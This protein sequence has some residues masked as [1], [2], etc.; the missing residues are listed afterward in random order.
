MKAVTAAILLMLP[1]ALPW[2]AWPLP[3]QDGPGHFGQIGVLY[4]QVF[5]PDSYD[6]SLHFQ[7]IFGPNRSFYYLGLAFAAV[8]GPETGA[9]WAL[10]ASLGL[11][12]PAVALGLRWAGLDW[13]G[14]IFATPLALGRLTACGFFP[15][16]AA[17]G[18]AALALGL[19][20]RLGRVDARRARWGLGAALLCLAALTYFTHAFV[21]LAV[22]AYLAVAML[23]A[24]GRR[25][26]GAVA[27]HGAAVLGVIALHAA[28]RVDTGA[29]GSALGAVLAALHAPDAGQLLRA[30]DWVAAWRRDGGVDDG[31]QALWLGSGLVVVWV[32]RGAAGAARWA[33]RLW[34]LASLAVIWVLGE[35]FGPPIR[36]WGGFLRVPSL[37]LL[38]G[39]LAFWPTAASHRGR[40]APAR[41]ASFAAMG[42]AALLVAFHL[43]SVRRDS[44]AEYAGLS[45]VLD[46]APP[47]RR[48]CA[49]W[50]DAGPLAA[51]PG[52]PHWYAGNYYVLRH[53]GR[54][55]HS[56]MGHPGSVYYRGDGPAP[57]PGWGE[58]VRFSPAQ[59][60]QHCDLFLVRV[61][62]GR[63]DRPF[64]GRT[65][66]HAEL[67]AA[68]G[69]WRLWGR[70]GDRSAPPPAVR[71]PSPR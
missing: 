26:P 42:A 35:N 13:R 39:L 33:P 25:K 31:L 15:N 51:Y 10:S 66:H 1:G 37:L 4:A 18:P 67:I 23:L 61:D 3:F 60:G 44:R 63:P 34:C 24:W 17:L 19:S 56:L 68:S 49:M 69:Q 64:D 29:G 20:V 45:V 14:G 55:G 48:M 57:L 27:A 65:R 32:S 62:P 70:A 47:G 58:G 28:S 50:F 21:G 30:W 52:A 12:G 36:W 41:W 38:T 54:A 46:R 8:A 43:L 7:G 40:H 11:F 6:P 2:M 9:R 22:A 53:G 16:V 5:A 71:A 59:H